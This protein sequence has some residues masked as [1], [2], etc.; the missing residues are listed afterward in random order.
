[1]G[2]LALSEHKKLS[3]RDVQPCDNKTFIKIKR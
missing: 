2:N 1:M 3:N